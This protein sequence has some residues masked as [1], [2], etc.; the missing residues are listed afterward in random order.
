MIHGREDD[1]GVV[2]RAVTSKAR[3]KV[4]CYE[5][6]DLRPVRRLARYA[7]TGGRTSPV[8]FERLS[9]TFWNTELSDF[10]AEIDMILR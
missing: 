7:S 6:P 9:L 8:R 1:Q 5:P 4:P 10:V 2:Y 3:E